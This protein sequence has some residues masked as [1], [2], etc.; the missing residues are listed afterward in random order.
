MRVKFIIHF[1]CP[2]LL[3]IIILFL[4]LTG[5]SQEVSKDIALTGA[6]HYSQEV[7]GPLV[8][9]HTQT[10]VDLDGV[11]QIYIFLLCRPDSPLS[12][13]IT[14]QYDFLSGNLL[15]YN[16]SDIVTAV[17]GANRSHVPVVQMYKGL[18][19]YI[20][21]FNKIK[22]LLVQTTSNEDWDIVSYVYPM[23]LEFW[24]E[25]R[26]PQSLKTLFVRTSDMKVMDREYVDQLIDDRVRN[27]GASE[28]QNRA[29]RIKKKWE[30]IESLV[31]NQ[32][33]ERGD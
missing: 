32:G 17:S 12:S 29:E 6:L 30:F 9:L 33:G 10:F 25:F 19:D 27:K 1:V 31:Q 15:D 28:D 4:P 24:I 16:S 22:N 3:G 7:F 26:T 8:H 2:I 14:S 13:L 20:L 21:N 5:S 23:P 11:P 18:P